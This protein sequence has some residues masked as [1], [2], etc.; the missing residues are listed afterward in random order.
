MQNDSS[1][2]GEAVRRG[3]GKMLQQ[4]KRKNSNWTTAVKKQ[5]VL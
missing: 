4:K 1:L 3:R 2:C 5:S